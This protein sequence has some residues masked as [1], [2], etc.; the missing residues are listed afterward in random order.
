MHKEE[1]RK[2]VNQHFISKLKDEGYNNDQIFTAIINAIDSAQCAL[3]GEV[4]AGY[5]SIENAIRQG[6]EVEYDG[7]MDGREKL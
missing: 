5:I 3:L 7:I 4:N 2:H 1:N 6:Y